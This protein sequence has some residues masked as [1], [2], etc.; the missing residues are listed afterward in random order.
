MWQCFLLWYQLSSL[1]GQTLRETKQGINK[2]YLALTDSWHW[3]GLHWEQNGDVIMAV[4]ASQITTVSII[5]STV[6][7]GEDQR[8][9]QSSASLVFA[10]GIHRWL[11]NSPHQGPVTRNMFP[12]HDVI[13]TYLSLI[14]AF[15]LSE[16]HM[17][18]SLYTGLTHKGTNNKMLSIFKTR[19]QMYFITAI[20]TQVSF[21]VPTKVS[22]VINGGW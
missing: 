3:L 6:C 4:L 2:L 7:L 11:V 8:K 22:P 18:H 17:R 1:A 19:F 12:F 5:Y 16:G 13:V 21:G 20:L 10:R 15:Y 9:H 14:V